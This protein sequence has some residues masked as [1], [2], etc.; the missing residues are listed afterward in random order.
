M[1]GIEKK[2]REARGEIGLKD[3]DEDEPID[4]INESKK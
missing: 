3:S 4:Y 1:K 2:H